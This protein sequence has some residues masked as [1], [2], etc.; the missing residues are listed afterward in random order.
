MDAQA[1]FGAG[2]PAQW[3]AG[4]LVFAPVAFIFLSRRCSWLRKILWATATQLPWLFIL[5]YGWV[6]ERRYGQGSGDIAPPPL[7][8]AIGWWTLAFP[9]GVYLLYRATR[10]WFPGETRAPAPP[11]G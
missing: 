7:T 9:W 4:L 1:L 6:L 2:G 10:S 5:A 8:E 3:L 11:A